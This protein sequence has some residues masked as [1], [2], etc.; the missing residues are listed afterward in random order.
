LLELTIALALIL[1][2]GV[3]ALS[4]LAIVS[5]R[6]PRLKVMAEARRS[7]AWTALALAEEP[8]RFLSTVQI[9]ITL[10]GILAGAFSGAALGARLTAILAEQGVPVRL[11]D[12]LGYGLVIG[13]ITYLSVIIGELVPKHLA[14]RDA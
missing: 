6:K 4:E 10:V 14:L 2:N 13:A 3:F 8:G 1:L 7:G 9:G 11:A 5:A 12:P